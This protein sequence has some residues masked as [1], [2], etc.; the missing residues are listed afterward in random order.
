MAVAAV[1]AAL[2]RNV[3]P[4][5][6]RRARA[7]AGVSADPLVAAVFRG[8]LVE[9][10]VPAQPHEADRGHAARRRRRR[11]GGGRGLVQAHALAVLL[12]DAVGGQ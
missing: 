10:A 6:A 9:V 4:A 12:E 5:S 11:S 8:A 1:R 7:E 2:Q 3:P